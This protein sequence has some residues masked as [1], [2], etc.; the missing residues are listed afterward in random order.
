MGTSFMQ[1]AHNPGRKPFPIAKAKVP[2]PA[3]KNSY[4][5]SIDNSKPSD[6]A[7]IKLHLKNIMRTQWRRTS[8]NA[9]NESILSPSAIAST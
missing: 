8:R 3:R 6:P 1:F 4:A 9:K 5:I 2:T 7:L